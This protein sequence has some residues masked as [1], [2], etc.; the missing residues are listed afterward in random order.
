MTAA[1]SMETFI[2]NEMIKK[3]PWLAF[4]PIFN[5][6]YNNCRSATCLQFAIKKYESEIKDL[7][8]AKTNN[9]LPTHHQRLKNAID[10]SIKNGSEDS[11][12]LSLM[13]VCDL[14]LKKTNKKLLEAQAQYQQKGS[15]LLIELSNFLTK[16]EFATILP[17]NP[18]FPVQNIAIINKLC[19]FISCYIKSSFIARQQKHEK[20]KAAR[21]EAQNLQKEKESEILTLTRKELNDTVKRLINNSPKIRQKKFNQNT[22]K[23][24]GLRNTARFPP[25]PVQNTRSTSKSKNG[26]GRR[27]ARRQ[28]V[29]ATNATRLTTT[30]RQPTM[31]QRSRS[32][33]KSRPRQ[34]SRS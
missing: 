27:V 11:D 4:P 1:A 30:T 21:M 6:L 5:I 16:L 29:A 33:P 14:E 18:E 34:G 22:S 9:I 31:R 19:N 26:F 25:P 13:F 7:Q 10:K 20:R 2:T 3:I 15:E 32:R 23:S 8:A 12:R 28:P 17:A 24:R